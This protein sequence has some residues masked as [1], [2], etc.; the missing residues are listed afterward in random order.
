MNVVNDYLDILQNVEATIIGV[1][2]D[3]PELRD[4]D[5][6]LALERLISQ[7]TREK[8]KLPALPINLPTRSLT[9]FQAIRDLSENRIDRTAIAE[10][11]DD[12]WG[13]RLPLRLIIPCLERLLK[14]AE[15]WHKRGGQRGY[16]EFIGQYL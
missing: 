16:L 12:V 11:P 2:K 14:S 9:V 10:V 15:T 4:P 1:Y 6:I 13:Y 7:Y 8:K 5:V 3:M